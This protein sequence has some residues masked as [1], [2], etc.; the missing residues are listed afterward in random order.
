MEEGASGSPVGWLRE[1]ERHAHVT[2]PLA[3]RAGLMRPSDKSKPRPWTGYRPHRS[4]TS[5][6]H[7]KATLV[8]PAGQTTRPFLK[9]LVRVCARVRACVCVC[10]CVCARVD[11]GF[12]VRQANFVSAT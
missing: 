1:L 8:P 7:M 5:L 11:E 6:S 4:G 3:T 9:Q 12:E 10:V 2:S